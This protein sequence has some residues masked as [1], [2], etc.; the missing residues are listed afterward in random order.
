M[1]EPPET[2][3]FLKKLRAHVDEN[4]E[5]K[6]LLAEANMWPEDSAA[7]FGD[8]DEC[9]MNYHFPIMPRMFMAVKMED[10]Y[11]I[12]D[13][14]DQTPDIPEACQWAIFLRNHD[15][16]TLEMVTD[17]ERDYMYKV[18]TKDPQA[19]INVG[20]R[21]R[22]APLLE[23]NRNKIELM[24]VLLFSLP[25]TPVIYYGDEIGMGD[26]FYLGDRDGVRTPMQWSADRN[27]GFSQAN[28][29]KLY[30]P[31]II[32]PEYKYE[33]VNVETQQMNS[34]SLLWWMKRIIAM[35]KKYKAFGR[36]DIHFLSP[37]CEDLAYTRSYEDEEILV[38]CNLSR[39]PQAAELDLEDYEG[40][41]PVEV[42]S[43]NKFPR[44][45]EDPYLFTMGPMAIIGF[46]EKDREHSEKA[47]IPAL[48]VKNWAEL[49]ETKANKLENKVL[50]NY[51][52][53]CRW[54]G[55]K[56]G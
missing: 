39:F 27:A 54:F 37:E 19:K 13:I 14:I 2:H 24:N 41:T 5:N 26:N 34:S 15:E 11:P 35:R 6:L 23:N 56:A 49:L 51:L 45:T 16:L 32:D 31:A 53:C 17:E 44:I 42:F 47:E 1:R 3:E 48:K 21:H 29:Q 8:G 10:R 9:H 18:Y 33:S 20:I 52:N 40:Y 4:F 30:L 43:H 55:G 7:Y 25:G 46:T 28:P 50:P 12:I 38:I 36:G 22:L